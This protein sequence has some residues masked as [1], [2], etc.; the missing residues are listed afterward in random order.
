MSWDNYG[1]LWQ[2]DHILPVSSFD[3]SLAH[4]RKQCW[5]FTNLQPLEADRNLEK[6]DRITEP[7]L[8]LLI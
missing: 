2:V 4:H 8:S 3:H 6:S 1:K 5:H 7:Q